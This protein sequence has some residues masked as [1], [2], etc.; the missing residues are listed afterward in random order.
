M[1]PPNPRVSSRSL[2][3]CK[4]PQISQAAG[5]LIW[6]ERRRSPRWSSE[7]DQAHEGIGPST[8]D[9][10]AQA[11]ARGFLRSRVKE[12][13][14]SRPQA[15]LIS[16]PLLGANVSSG[17]EA[18][19]RKST[20][21]QRRRRVPSREGG[22]LSKPGGRGNE[23]GKGTR[24]ITR[25]GQ[26][27][28]DQLQSGKLL[29]SPLPAACGTPFTTSLRLFNWLWSRM[30]TAS[31]AAVTGP[32]SVTAVSCETVCAAV[33]CLN[34]KRSGSFILLHGGDLTVR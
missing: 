25:D 21:D 31:W 15:N 20:T 1:G 27:L 32:P 11:D 29:R 10:W 14:R 13:R 18:T 6:H 16:M 34:M 22:T 26:R 28:R 19:A 3:V 2:G 23:D 12:G 8:P 24:E 30:I 7:S 33:V 17:I 9:P 4:G 5:S